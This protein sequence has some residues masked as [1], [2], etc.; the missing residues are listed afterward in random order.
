MVM[1]T[2]N[3]WLSGL[4]TILHRRIFFCARGKSAGEVWAIWRK[5]IF[6]HSSFKV[7]VMT[8]LKPYA[9]ETS[10]SPHWELA[11]FYN[12]KV[13]DTFGNCQRPVFSLGP[14]QHYVSLLTFGPYWSS[15]LQDNNGR[16]THTHTCCTKWSAFRCQIKGFRPWVRNYLFLRNYVTL[17]GGG[18]S[19][20]FLKAYYQQL[21]VARYQVSFYA[22]F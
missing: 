22:I 3:Y 6:P 4:N 17:E 20:N 10:K 9:Y 2:D 12:L 11:P 7:I 5:F 15:K 13:L 8:M 21:P 1:V 16:K 19:P 18:G 14:C